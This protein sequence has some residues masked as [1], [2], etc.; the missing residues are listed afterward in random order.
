VENCPPLPSDGDSTPRNYSQKVCP[1]KTR[2]P[3]SLIG[4]RPAI[5]SRRHGPMVACSKGKLL[6]TSSNSLSP[7]QG[8]RP[9]DLVNFF[10][11]SYVSLFSYLL[12]QQPIVSLYQLSQWHTLFH[13]TF[14][15]Q[16]IHVSKPNSPNCVPALQMPAK[17]RHWCM[18]YL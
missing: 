11:F 9:Y 4:L 6:V 5:G 3:I 2:C 1:I 10:L 17:Q 8:W 18:K 14:T 12:P 7:F 15:C 16:H 13:Q